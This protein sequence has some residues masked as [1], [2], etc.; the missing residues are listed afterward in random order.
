MQ[1]T[2]LHETFH[3]IA[4]VITIKA[5]DLATTK[6]HFPSAFNS[7]PLDKGYPRK[8]SEDWFG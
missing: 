6:I 5:H 7:S 4:H 8:N 2:F 3:A 1:D